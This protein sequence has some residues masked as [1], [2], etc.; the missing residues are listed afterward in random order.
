MLLDLFSSSEHRERVLHHE[1]GHFLAAYYLD[2]PITGYTLNAWDAFKVG[3][4]GMGGVVVD[5]EALSA[6]APEEIPLM[7]DRLS[8]VWMAG[9]AAENLVYGNAEGGGDDRAKL[10]QALIFAASPPSTYQQKVR[11]AQLQA[12]S[13][14]QKHQAS[15]DALVKAMEAKASVEDCC[16]AIASM[17]DR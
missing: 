2:I 15:Y 4:P 11:W 16:K 9:I 3:Q 13:L 6:K 10:K 8:T 12:K 7:L 14:L 5:T 1:A 17:N